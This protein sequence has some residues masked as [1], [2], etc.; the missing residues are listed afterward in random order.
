MNVLIWRRG[1]GYGL[2]GKE[3]EE[4]ERG[5][6]GKRYEGKGNSQREKCEKKREIGSK[7]FGMEEESGE[8]IMRK[9]KF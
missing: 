6:K 4:R 5:T 2:E 3:V 7:M 8:K 1:N 9:V